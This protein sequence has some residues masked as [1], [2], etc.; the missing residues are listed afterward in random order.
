MT[1]PDKGLRHKGC[2]R[3]STACVGVRAQPVWTTLFPPF[4]EHV[5]EHGSALRSLPLPQARGGLGR[6]ALCFGSEACAAGR[7]CWASPCRAW[8]GTTLPPFALGKGRV[9]EGCSC[10]GSEACAARRDCWAGPCRAWLG[11]TPPP[12]AAGKGRAGEGC[13]LLLICG[14]RGGEGLLG[15]PLPSMARHYVQACSSSGCSSPKIR[16]R[17][18]AQVC[19]PAQSAIRS[20]RIS[21]STCTRPRPSPCTGTA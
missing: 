16:A 8:L 20:W 15:R 21:S 10:F 13:S 19:W 9:G 11:T 4:A 2:A 12:F 17:R 1:S 5:A 3:L 7:D 18:L 14:L 6:G